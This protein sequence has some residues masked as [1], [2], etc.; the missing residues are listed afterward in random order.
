MIS[1]LRLGDIDS[2][3]TKLATGIVTA[4]NRLKRSQAKS[5]I[6]ILLTDGE[7]SQGDMDPRAAIAIA[8]KLGIKIYTVGI[9]SEQPEMFIHP[10][11]GALQKPCV[12][13]ELLDAIAQ[14]AEGKPEEF[15]C[16]CLVIARLFQSSNNCLALHVLHLAAEV[17][18]GRHGRNRILGRKF[19]VKVGLADATACAQGNCPLKHVLEF[20]DVAGKWVVQQSG[21]GVFVKR[22]FRIEP[23]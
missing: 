20:P 12:N 21:T 6:M 15:G 14:L 17:P 18:R 13:K 9:G 10:L 22:S 19:Q 1:Q 16:R 5:K 7:P 4:A 2:E 23:L 11:Y 3:G 8:K